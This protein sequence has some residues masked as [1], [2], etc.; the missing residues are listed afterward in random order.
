M[1]LASAFLTGGIRSHV[2]FVVL[3]GEYELLRIRRVPRVPYR[4]ES[5]LANATPRPI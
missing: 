4:E 3:V 5:R 1:T 2:W